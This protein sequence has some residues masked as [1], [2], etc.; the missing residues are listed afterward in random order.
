MSERTVV[1]TSTQP[2]RKWPP[3]AGSQAAGKPAR[4]VR[5]RKELL[6][7]Y[8]RKG[9]PVPYRMGGPWGREDRPETLAE[10]G[11]RQGTRFLSPCSDRAGCAHETPG[12][13]KVCA[14]CGKPTAGARFCPPA[15]Q[16]RAGGL[17]P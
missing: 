13:V 14:S 1:D 12:I 4:R 17:E 11:F 3:P 5:T 10:Y 15:S 16:L 6:A 2:P 8:R 7:A 9:R